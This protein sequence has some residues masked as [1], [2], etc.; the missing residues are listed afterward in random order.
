MKRYYL[1]AF[2]VCGLNLL[3]QPYVPFPN[4]TATWGIKQINNS[5]FGQTVSYF[6]EI[7]KGD[8]LI[9][10]TSFKKVYKNNISISNLVGLYREVN[11]KI[12]AK[13]YPYPDTNQVL[14]Y[15]YNLNVGDTFYDKYKYLSSDIIWKYKLQSITIT[16]L[17]TDVRKQFDF[18]LVGGPSFPSP[19]STQSWI[20]GI[21]STTTLFNAREASP[22]YANSLQSTTINYQLTCFEHKF[23]QYMMQTCLV[24][25]LEDQ[26]KMNNRIVLYPN[27]SSDI[28]NVQIEGIDDKTIKIQVLNPLNQLLIDEEQKTSIN[29][30]NLTNGIYFVKI[31]I[32]N[33]LII[34]K[35]IIKE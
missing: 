22:C 10:G 25:D 4:D 6:K 15:D 24:L 13:I 32:N 19:C 3:S 21:G 28:L 9:N 33:K 23:I 14:I 30:K 35:K 5:S 20:E 8:T 16:T 31:S 17:T 1:F 7:Q 12:Y 26:Q 27:P 11:K 29:L 18:I 34:L 2:I